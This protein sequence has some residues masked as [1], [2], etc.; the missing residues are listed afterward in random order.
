[1]KIAL[2]LAL[3]LLASIACAQAPSVVKVV[4]SHGRFTLVR[5]GKPYHI[6]GAGG[7]FGFDR[8]ASFGGNSTRTWGAEEF[9]TVFD[10]AEAN[11]LTVTAG[12]WLQHGDALDYTKRDQVAKQFAET[13]NVIRKHKNHASLLIWALGNEAEGEGKTVEYW[14]ALQDLAA[15]C[16]R[17]D[18]NHPTM[19]VICEWLDPKLEMIK[20]YCP[21]IDIV[22]INSY[23]GSATAGERFRKA[24]M[25]RPYV[26]TEWG[27]VGHWEVAKTRWNAPLE[28]T[29]TNKV[30]W[31]TNG[32]RNNVQRNSDLCLGS[33]AFLW[34]HKVEKTPTWFGL[35]LPDGSRTPMLDAI[36]RFW[37]A[38]RAEHPC[39]SIKPIDISQTDHLTPGSTVTAR[40]SAK[41]SDG[42]P[43][44]F[45][46][47]LLKEIEGWGD[48]S[49]AVAAGTVEGASI[50]A[51]GSSAKI[52]LPSSPGAYRLYV[53]ARDSHG[54]G[55]TANVPIFVGP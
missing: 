47:T 32:Y 48:S 44:Q 2:L 36:M 10:R 49:A 43:C 34:G 7:D 40:V 25:D 45:V 41:A 21:D 8:L 11:G 35:W 42:K 46:W 12:I 50:E 27:P 38:K 39:P 18:P 37:T 33:Y 20:K 24:K 19:T 15:M 14:K 16:H 54:G 55:A 23:G 30:K 22:G 3:S 31:F 28:P 6:H 5:N 51:K 29:S 26:L 9:D 13:Q 4:R 1:M 53:V 17:E 52:K